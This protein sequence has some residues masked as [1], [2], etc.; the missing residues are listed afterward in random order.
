MLQ[1]VSGMVVSAIQNAASGLTGPVAPGEMVVLSGFRLGPDQ[2]VA[3]VPASDGNFATTLAG[4]TVQIN[5]T[6]APL[7][8]TWATQVAAIV[9]ESVSSGVGQ[10][11]VAW[12]GRVTAPFPISVTSAAPGIFTADLSGMGNAA[13]TNQKGTVDAPANWGDTITLFATGLGQATPA[14]ILGGETVTPLSVGIAQGTGGGITKIKIP[15]QQGENCS[16]SIMI[17][18]GGASSQAG[19]ILPLALCI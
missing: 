4:T 13:T 1:P 5:G 9:P 6:A 18:V 2:L 14:V 7:V 10:V 12:Q 3:A 8:Y 15:I 17:S 11:T 19:V 16:Q